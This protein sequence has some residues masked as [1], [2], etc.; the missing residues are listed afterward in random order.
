MPTRR[1]LDAARDDLVATRGTQFRRVV[2]PGAGR[3]RLRPRR[4]VAVVGRRASSPTGPR[5]GCGCRSRRSCPPAPCSCSRRCSGAGRTARSPRSLFL[6]ALS[7]RSCSSTAWPA[8]RSAPAGSTADVA[9]GQPASLLRVGRRA[10]RARRRVRPRS[11]ARCSRAPTPRRSSPG[12]TCG[13]GRRPGQTVSPLVEI[14]GRLVDQSDIEVFTVREHRRGRTGGSPS[15]D[16]VRRR[17]SGRRAA[18]TGRPTASCR[19]RR[20]VDGRRRPRAPALRDH[21]ARADL[22]ARRVRGRSV[23]RRSTTSTCRWDAESATLIVD[24]DV[25]RLRRLRRTRSTRL[26]P[27][28]D[29]RTSSR[30]G[31]R[32]MPDDDRRRATSRCRTAFSDRVARPGRERHRRAPTPRTTRRWRCRTASAT[33]SST[34]STC[35]RGHS[36]RRHRGVPLPT[37]SAGYCE[38]FAGIVRGDGP[39]RRPPGPGRGR[40]SRPGEVDA[41]TRALYHVRGKHAH[42]WPEVYIGASAGCRSS[43]RRAGASPAPRA[44]PG[45]PEQQVDSNDAEPATT[46]P[47]DDRRRRRRADDGTRHDGDPAG[48]DGRARRRRRGRRRRSRATGASVGRWRRRVA[49]RAGLVGV[50]GA[51]AVRVGVPTGHESAAGAGGARADDADDQVRVA[52]AESVEAMAVLG[53]APPGVG[54]AAEFAGRAGARGSTARRYPSLATTSRRPS[55][56]RRRPTARTRPGRFELSE[57]IQRTVQAQATRE[58]RVRAALDPRRS[59]PRRALAPPRSGASRTPAADRTP[60]TRAVEPALTRR[61]RSSVVLVLLEAV[62]HALAGA[63]EVVAEA[64]AAH[65]R[66]HLLQPGPAELAGV[67]LEPERRGR[68]SPGS[69]NER[70]HEVTS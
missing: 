51:R 18:R 44:T 32:G 53:V 39:R 22:A 11:A 59:S 1:T 20:A 38:Q 27:R 13:D 2:A 29:A 26:S 3:A 54:D 66:G 55:T 19:R 43:R 48:P 69:R 63:A 24:T 7:R 61:S 28:F 60:P 42:A 62:A 5:S 35:R 16:D 8:S 70:Q 68:A 36:E 40:A 52:W 10:G 14:R 58:Q 25:R 21:G 15:L 34:T 50:G 31:R 46:V 65:R 49:G 37:T 9:A 64:G 30:A 56:R 57:H 33:T 6:G 4:R 12:A 17:A 67:A 45:V 23:H 47:A 41:E